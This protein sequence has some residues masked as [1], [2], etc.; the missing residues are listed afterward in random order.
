M[1]RT[2]FP[3]QVSGGFDVPYILAMQ[4][5][6]VQRTAGWTGLAAAALFGLGSLLWWPWGQVR[7]GAT[8]RAIAEFYSQDQ[9]RILIGGAVSVIALALFVCF[10][11]AVKQLVPASRKLTGDVALAGAVVTTVAGLAAETINM[12]G[13][14]RAAGD[15]V[16]AQAMYEIPQVFG[17]Y[18]SA[19]GVGIFALAVGASSLLPRWSAAVLGVTGV[20]LLSPA[21][22]Y[23]VEVA[24]G[25]LVLVSALVGAQLL[26]TEG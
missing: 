23:V 24:G 26:T 20:V 6:N 18:T 17:G 16:L 10:A 5:S 1:V 22:L 15:P 14:L 3:R 7:P 9:A 21:A 8:P 11:A 13:A 12:G 2:L 19:V 25:G 4:R